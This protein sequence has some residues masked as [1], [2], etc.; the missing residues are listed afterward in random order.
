MDP[1]FVYSDVSEEEGEK[2]EEQSE[3]SATEEEECEQM[4]QTHIDEFKA[5]LPRPR[6]TQAEEKSVYEILLNLH[7]HN[8]H[9]I[10][11]QLNANSVVSLL[12][13]ERE[14]SVAARTTL[15][16]LELVEPDTD[17]R[18]LPLLLYALRFIHN[19]VDGED[20]A[21]SSALRAYACVISGQLPLQFRDGPVI[22]MKRIAA[23][24]PDIASHAPPLPTSSL[25]R[26]AGCAR[27]RRGRRGNFY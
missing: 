14:S 7:C 23:L 25:P 21:I 16:L 4:T 5:L 1:W 6:E 20:I 2:E 24:I 17:D 19:A 26:S 15:F 10:T 12:D 11:S 8:Q 27:D 9:V 13:H 3:T 22:C 18:W